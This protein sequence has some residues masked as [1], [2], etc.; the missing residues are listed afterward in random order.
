VGRNIFYDFLVIASGFET[1]WGAL[2]NKLK[3]LN[4]K[5]ASCYFYEYSENFWHKLLKREYR[6]SECVFLLPPGPTPDPTA[7]QS[8][9]LSIFCTLNIDYQIPISFEFKLETKKMKKKTISTENENKNE[10][11]NM[12]ARAREC[13]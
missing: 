4:T 6:K 12:C 7:A 10:N 13:E 9:K 2:T 5:F 8:V 1:D 3:K 11:E